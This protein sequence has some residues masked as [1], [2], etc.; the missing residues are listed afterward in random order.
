MKIVKITN[1][2]M[3]QNCYVLTK[4]NKNAI[5]I[6]PGLDTKAILDYL[7]KNKLKPTT[8]LLTHGHFDHIFSVKALKDK[9]AKIYVTE[10]DGPKLLDRS[11]IWGLLLIFKQ[12][13]LFQMDFCLVGKMNLRAKNLT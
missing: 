6:D 7:E 3:K 13:P 2:V 9:G 1:G 12:N 11:L 8:V 10:A 5:L 4:D